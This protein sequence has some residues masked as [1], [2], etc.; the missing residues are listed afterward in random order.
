MDI[1]GI[2]R[3]TGEPSISLVSEGK[4]RNLNPDSP[5]GM[6]ILEAYRALLGDGNK[7]NF[8]GRTFNIVNGAYAGKTYRQLSLVTPFFIIVLTKYDF[9]PAGLPSPPD[10]VSLKLSFDTSESVAESDSNEDS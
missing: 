9:T 7:V 8:L 4:W 3:S 6:S 2:V 5:L 10:R 1:R